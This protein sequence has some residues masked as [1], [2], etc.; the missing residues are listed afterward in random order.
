M[1]ADAGTILP[2]VIDDLVN[3]LFE[4]REL[5]AGIAP[6]L[7]ALLDGRIPLLARDVDELSIDARI[8]AV[9]AVAFLDVLQALAGTL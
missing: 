9:L 4:L 7:A 3:E 8:L 1:H 5:K 2:L 6:R